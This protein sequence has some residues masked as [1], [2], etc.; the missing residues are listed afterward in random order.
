MS[1]AWSYFYIFLI[2]LAINTIVFSI[3]IDPLNSDA[4][5]II[6]SIVFGLF[7]IGGVITFFVMYF[8]IFYPTQSITFEPVNDCQVQGKLTKNLQGSESYSMLYVNFKYKGQNMLGY[9]CQ[10]NQNTR[11]VGGEPF[12]YKFITNGTYY[13]CVNPVKD[14]NS[15]DVAPQKIA[16][17]K[18][19]RVV[20][21]NQNN[22]Y[23]SSSRQNRGK[24]KGCQPY[25]FSQVKIPSWVCVD[26]KMSQD[27]LTKPQKCYVNFYNNE[28]KAY[29]N[30][31]ERRE[32]RG[33]N[34]FALI[35]FQYPLYYQQDAFNYMIIFAYYPLL[36][37]FDLIYFVIYLGYNGL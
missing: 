35:S 1:I 34:N 11:T 37:S 33:V 32:L 20:I 4:A 26:F 25:N 22:Y 9:G 15:Y 36:L 13:D 7:F 2:L 17:S 23:H 24:S 18:R 27:N 19:Q 8:V 16:L 10:S 30:A 12:P 3:L 5:I 21:Y 6:K 28:D 29:E 31:Q 14:Q